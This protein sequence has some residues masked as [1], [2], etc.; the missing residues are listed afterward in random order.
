MKTLLLIAVLATWRAGVS[1]ASA[2]HLA[3][4]QSGTKA[5]GE[6]PVAGGRD[7][8]PPS[9]TLDVKNADVREVLASLKT[10]CGVKNMIID[11]DVP[12]SAAT[13]YFRDVPCESAFRIV[14]RT[15]GLTSQPPVNSVV[16]VEPER[17]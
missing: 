11:P 10:Q 3:R 5:P 2:G 7:A 17:R 8:R 12:A 4:Q 13:F 6:T 16:Q 9:V 14:L 1:P 15:F